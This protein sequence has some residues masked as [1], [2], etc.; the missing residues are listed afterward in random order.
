MTVEMQ[1]S[2]SQVRQEMVTNC[3]SGGNQQ[4]RDPL[5]RDPANVDQYAQI[6]LAFHH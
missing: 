4:R 2:I 3:D 6:Y 1:A 5:C